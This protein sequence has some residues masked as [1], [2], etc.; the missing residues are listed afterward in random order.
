MRSSN[1]ARTSTLNLR[2]RPALRWLAIALLIFAQ[3]AF[4]NHVH[5]L[6][7]AV[8]HECTLCSQL[9]AVEHGH[10]GPVDLP[11]L[12]LGTI[13]ATAVEQIKPLV[14]S[15]KLLPPSRAPPA[16]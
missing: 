13:S 5:E 10:T 11:I 1:I 4:S 3:L 7:E 12:S 6:D 15:G 14:R 2:A 8:N 16:L 9:S